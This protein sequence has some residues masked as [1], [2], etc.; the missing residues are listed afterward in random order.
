MAYSRQ[1]SILCVAMSQ[2]KILK[3][4]KKNINEIFL[5]DE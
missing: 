3:D 5:L 1:Q 4:K 2:V